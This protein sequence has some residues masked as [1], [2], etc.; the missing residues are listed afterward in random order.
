MNGESIHAFTKRG[1]PKT[2]VRQVSSE[3]SKNLKLEPQLI[4]RH[5]FFS[6]FLLSVLLPLAVETGRLTG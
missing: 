2:R 3:L 4:L 1:D 6:F 5:C